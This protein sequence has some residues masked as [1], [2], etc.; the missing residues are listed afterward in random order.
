MEYSVNH[1]GTISLLLEKNKIRTLLFPICKNILPILSIEKWKQARD[2]AQLVEHLFTPK[3]HGLEFGPKTHVKM[4]SVMAHAYNPSTA[5]VETR[6][7]LG[8][9]DS[10][11]SQ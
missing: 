4:L 9:L 8:L 5:E 10:Q 7:S 6:W 11:F 1:I 3:V 2:K